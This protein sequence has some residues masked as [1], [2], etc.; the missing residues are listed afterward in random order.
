MAKPIIKVRAEQQT[1]VFCFRRVPGVFRCGHPPQERSTDWTLSQDR[2]SASR[3]QNNQ[4][5]PR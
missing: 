4:N 5:P 1:Q 2:L 3:F